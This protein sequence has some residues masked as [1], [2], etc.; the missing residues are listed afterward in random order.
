MAREQ[1]AMARS[2]EA[3]TWRVATTPNGIIRAH[4]FFD[5]EIK[6]QTNCGQSLMQ[7]GIG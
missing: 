5:E 7:S 4:S 3:I 6:E 2:A 1:T